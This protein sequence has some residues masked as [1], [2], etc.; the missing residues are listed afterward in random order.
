MQRQ[1]D[2]II[3]YCLKQLNRERT[4]F[5]IFHLLKG[6]KSSQTIQDAHLFSLKRFFGVCEILTRETFEEIVQKLHKNEWITHCGNQRY[7]LTPIGE[8]ILKTYQLPSFINGWDFHPLTTLFWER[9]SLFIQ[10]ASNYAYHETNYIPIQKDESVQ[11]WIKMTLKKIMIPKQDIGKMMNKELMDCLE[12]A[13][14]L[15]PSLLVFRLTGYQKIGLT[16]FQAAEKF[17]LDFVDYHISFIHIL[18]YLL[19]VVIGNPARFPL[20]KLLIDGVKENNDLTQSTSITLEMLVQG[21][22]LEMIAGRRNLKVS[23]IEDHIVELALQM[24]DFSIDPYVERELCE[25]ILEISR[26]SSTKQLKVI[27]DKVSTASYFQIRLVLAK[28]GGAK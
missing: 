13:E 28:Y 8:S 12:N 26:L 25:E 4:V 11:S 27:K 24:E 21:H 15:N 6:K 2:S 20:L 14:A 23:T 3:L 19:S 17:Q 1:M 16:S 5:S 22:S 18:H 9:L 7:T 10:V